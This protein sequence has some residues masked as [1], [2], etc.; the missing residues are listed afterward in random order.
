MSLRSVPDGRSPVPFTWWLPVVALLVLAVTTAAVLPGNHPLAWLIG[1]LVA[2]IAGYALAWAAIRP[3]PLWTGPH[4]VLPGAAQQRLDRSDPPT[5][6]IPVIRPPRPARTTRLLV[7]SA[8]FA[9]GSS[10]GWSLLVGILYH[11]KAPTFRSAT[12]RGA[13]LLVSVLN[14]VITSVL[15]ECGMALLILAAA[16]LAERLLPRR[17]DDRSVA[18]TAILV[19]TVAR[20]A[21][22]IPLWGVGAIGRIG[23][24]FALA[25]LF[26]RTRRIWPLLLVHTL[27]DTLALQTLNS[28]SL[29]VRGFCA[30]AI[31]AWGITGVTFAV[32]ATARSRRNLRPARL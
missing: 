28:P 8:A 14:S 11:P 31:L 18:V 21:L 16:G 27:W 29:G 22:H 25:W 15:E 23:L 5:I 6:R 7:I 32:I 13:G 26:Y 17:W 20:T 19:G 24:S 4:L 10:S 2:S 1:A 9:I 12:T 3:A 30:L